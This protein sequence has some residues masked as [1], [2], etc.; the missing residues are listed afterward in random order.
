MLRRMGWRRDA[1]EWQAQQWTRLG[2]DLRS[3]YFWGGPAGGHYIDP[4][5]S[6]QAQWDVNKAWR[7]K[8]PPMQC[9]RPEYVEAMRHTWAYLTGALPQSFNILMTRDTFGELDGGY[10]IDPASVCWEKILTPSYLEDPHRHLIV[11][12]YYEERLEQLKGGD[13]PPPGVLTA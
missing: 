11:A 10:R 4:T 2:L 8:F 7:A 12:Y 1:L 5:W 6:N 13:A 3:G 9:D